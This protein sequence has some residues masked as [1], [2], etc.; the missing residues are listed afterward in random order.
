MLDTGNDGIDFWA[1]SNQ[2]KGY[3]HLKSATS[4]DT[5]KVFE[6]D[7]GKGFSYAFV[8]GDITYI[9]EKEK[10]TPS[11]Q[12]YPN[13][14]NDFVSVH[15]DLQEQ[16][17]LN[18]CIYDLTGKKIMEK[19]YFNTSFVDSKF[20]FS[21]EKSGIYLCRIKS[22]NKTYTKKISVIK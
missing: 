17:N 5:Y 11:I 9:N 16:A 10:F 14:T 7:F 15:I 4:W 19:N 13:P 3:I 22:N 8:I 1:N 6:P 2:G 20:D 18:V 21:T 12:I